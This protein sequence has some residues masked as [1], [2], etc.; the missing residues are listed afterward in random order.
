MKIGFRAVLALA[1]VCAAQPAYSQGF[2]GA[3]MAGLPDVL[4]QAIGRSMNGYMRCDLFVD[5]EEQ[6][7]AHAPGTQL[8]SDYFAAA[9]AGKPRST[10]FKLTRKTRWTSG[11]SVAD[12]TNLDRQ[13]D[14]LAVAGNTLEPL[15]LRFYRAGTFTTAHG[16]WAVH[17]PD[18]SI[19]GVYDGVFERE[20]KIWKFRTLTLL[21]PDD[22]IVPAN[23]Y[24]QKPGDADEFEV[25]AARTGVERTEKQLAKRKAKFIA[26]DERARAVEVRTAGKKGSA[27]AAA[28]S[29]RATAEAAAKKVA[30]SE[31][32]L[33]ELRESLAKAETRRAE[34]RALIGPARNA[35]NFRETYDTTVKD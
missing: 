32:D 31:K 18:G 20:G 22:E 15:P 24:C 8:M 5:K 34:Y 7:E 14:P 12:Q 4:G 11:D 2:S 17:A 33:A 16:Q 28:A 10:L 3:L 9:S 21:G 30:E 35:E 25:D 29:L 13:I 1:A 27:N 19:A 23:P 26:A 6:F